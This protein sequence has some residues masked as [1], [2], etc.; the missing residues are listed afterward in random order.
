[1]RLTE[2]AFN[3]AADR[4][5]KGYR[6]VESMGRYQ[7]VRS[8]RHWLKR[9]EKDFMA[10]YTEDPKQRPFFPVKKVDPPKD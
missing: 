4:T 10:T 6:V 5:R 3:E 7:V 1:M 8:P 9:E 2:F